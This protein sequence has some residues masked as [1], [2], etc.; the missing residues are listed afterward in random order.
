MLVEVARTFE[1]HDERVHDG[2]ALVLR[3]EKRSELLDGIE[4]LAVVFRMVERIELHGAD[5][6]ARERRFR[7]HAWKRVGRDEFEKARAQCA[8]RRRK[9]VI[10]RFGCIETVPMK[11]HDA[12]PLKAR[13]NRSGSA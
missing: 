6:A 11:I 7:A 4:Q 13:L 1:Q 3:V 9:R 2:A 8:G 10:A 12:A 5:R